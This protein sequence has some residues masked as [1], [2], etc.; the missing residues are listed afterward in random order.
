MGLLRQ[1]LV[2]TFQLLP[3]LLEG[4]VAHLL[5]LLQLFVV[6]HVLLLH[7]LYVVD[8]TVELLL[9]VLFVVLWS[10]RDFVSLF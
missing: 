8:Q 4:L 7:R 2:Q 3:P 10:R 9:K 5:V 6:L 1:V